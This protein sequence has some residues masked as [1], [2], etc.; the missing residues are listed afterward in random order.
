MIHAMPPIQ[1]TRDRLRPF[2]RSALLSW[3]FFAAGAGL[4][5]CTQ[6][7]AQQASGSGPS[8]S[9]GKKAPS[10]RQAIDPIMPHMGE[11]NWIV[12][13][14]SSF[15]KSSHP[16]WKTVPMAI[17]P[18]DALRDVLASAKAYGHVKP[19]V[20]LDRELYAVNDA[21]F[22]DINAFREAVEGAS[23]NLF[24]DAAHDESYIIGMLRQVAE[25]HRVIVIKTPSRW[26]YSN[27]YVQFTRSNWTPE[28]EAAL[29]ERLSR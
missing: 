5:G 1:A 21:E 25:H 4:V 28:Q 6:S 19:V 9:A 18:V 22:P 17:D 15:P 13:A 26:P 14:D 20:W 2:I 24:L 7:S 11:G 10:F 29:R 16:G 23:A 12:I 3:A 27:I 8:G